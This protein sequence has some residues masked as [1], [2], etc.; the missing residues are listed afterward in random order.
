MY[1]APPF[2]A[3]YFLMQWAE[4][5]YVWA[6]CLDTDHAISLRCGGQEQLLE[7]ERGTAFEWRE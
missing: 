7:L 2:V 3:A 4:K 5:R 6:N 1:V